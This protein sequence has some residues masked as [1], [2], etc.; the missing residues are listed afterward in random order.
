[1]LSTWQSVEE[2]V[3]DQYESQFELI[4]SL[5]REYLAIVPTLKHSD[6]FSGLPN[7]IIDMGIMSVLY[8]T[9][10]KC[11][12]P[13]IRRESLSLVR[14]VSCQEGMLNNQVYAAVAA[15]VIA[16][17]EGA[18]IREIPLTHAKDIPGSARFVGVILF[19]SENEQD[20]KLRFGRF[21]HE[22]DGEW[23]EMEEDLKYV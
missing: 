23:C 15:K 9:I 2:M 7:F 5:V 21:E 6:S 13:S 4:N 14:Q 11:R 17:E 16:I 19:L 22:K 1:M 10:L 20:M 12:N 8:F 3:W 18:A